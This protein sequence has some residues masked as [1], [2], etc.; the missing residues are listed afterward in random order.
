MDNCVQLNTLWPFHYRFI[1]VDIKDHVSW[2]VFKACGIRVR[3]MKEMEKEGSPFRLMVCSIKK[4]DR[5][6]LADA[7]E[8]LRNS[9]ML[10]GYRDYDK[11]CGLLKA[12]EGA[13]KENDNEKGHKC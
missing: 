8:Q 2:R 1:Y 13:I 7:L 3:S 6:K 11:M 10:M 9:I 5:E 12:A 4:K